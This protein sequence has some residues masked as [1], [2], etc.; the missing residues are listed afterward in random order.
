MSFTGGF[1]VTA[2]WLLVLCAWLW[3]ASPRRRRLRRALAPLALF[4]VGAAVRVGLID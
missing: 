3:V 1:Y 4:L 2:G